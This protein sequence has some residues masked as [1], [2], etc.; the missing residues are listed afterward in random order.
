MLKSYLYILYTTVVINAVDLTPELLHTTSYRSCGHD[1][2]V[3][4]LD[5]DHGPARHFVHKQQ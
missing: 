5:G 4:I 1:S 3:Y 2:F